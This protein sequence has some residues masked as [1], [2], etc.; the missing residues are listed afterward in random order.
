[1]YY[2][3]S[4]L[5][6]PYRDVQ[7]CCTLVRVPTIVPTGTSLIAVRAVGLN[8]ATPVAITPV[9]QV[10]YT[11][12]LWRS[13]LYTLSIFSTRAFGQGN[14]SN[15]WYYTCSILVPVRV[16]LVRIVVYEVTLCCKLFLIPVYKYF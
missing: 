6:F 15:T 10:R 12:H 8:E 9:Y 7:Y 14:N 1:M 11:L 2:T 16:Y 3:A 4:L 13:H 5:M